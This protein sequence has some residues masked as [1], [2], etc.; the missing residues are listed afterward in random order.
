[1][2]CQTDKNNLQLKFIKD[3][4][5][6]NWCA[7]VGINIMNITYTWKSVYEIPKYIKDFTIKIC[8][9]SVCEM[10]ILNTNIIVYN[11]K[12]GNDVRIL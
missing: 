9:F 2:C 10:I 11:I 8:Q 4:S 6:S 3:L 12:N 5:V 7:A 1:M